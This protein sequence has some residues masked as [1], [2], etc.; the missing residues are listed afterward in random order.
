MTHEI[1][2]PLNEKNTKEQKGHRNV[3]MD[4]QARAFIDLKTDQR[5]QIFI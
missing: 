4:D 2:S 3:A 1:S 5:I